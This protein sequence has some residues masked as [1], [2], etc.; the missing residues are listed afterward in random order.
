LS[1]MGIM[2]AA[3]QW[4]MAFLFIPAL[5]GQTAVPLLS[6]E[7]GTSNGQARELLRTLRIVHYTFAVPVLATLVIGAPLILSGYGQSFQSAWLPFM[8]LQCATFLQVIQAPYVKYLEA[9]GR[10]WTNFYLNLAWAPIML[11]LSG[12]LVRYGVLGICIAQLAAFACFGVILTIHTRRLIN[13]DTL[14]FESTPRSP[15]D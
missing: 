14:D 8:V 2:T 5:I 4:R 11:T 13:T 3:N 1:E 15:H 7:V 12:L 9:T 6:Q 10:M